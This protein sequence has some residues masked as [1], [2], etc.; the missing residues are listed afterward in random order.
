MKYL[1]LSL[2]LLVACAEPTDQTKYLYEV[3][4]MNEE[5]TILVDT[6]QAGWADRYGDEILF[7]DDQWH[8]PHSSYPANCSYKRLQEVNW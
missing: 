5:S 3:K 7:R 8:K 1:I 2:F 6:V 4:C